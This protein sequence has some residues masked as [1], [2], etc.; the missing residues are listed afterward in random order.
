MR[1]GG[2][3]LKSCLLVGRLLAQYGFTFQVFS[4]LDFLS[5]PKL[6]VFIDP[7]GTD[8]MSAD[9]AK[10]RALLEKKTVINLLSGFSVAVKHYLRGED[11]IYYK[12][13]VS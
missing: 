5:S 8:T 7:A 6:V 3:G 12:Y 11:S 1:A 10:A 4:S 2:C 9:E 13:A